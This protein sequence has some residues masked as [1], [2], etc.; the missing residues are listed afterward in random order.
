MAAWQHTKADNYITVDRFDNTIN[1]VNRFIT[2]SVSDR[3]P[4][5]TPE[6]Y[7][8]YDNLSTNSR[9]TPATTLLR[10]DNLQRL[11]LHTKGVGCSYD[12][13]RYCD[14]PTYSNPTATSQ[15]IELPSIETSK[16]MAV[17]TALFPLPYLQMLP[18]P[19][20]GHKNL[21]SHHRLVLPSVQ[22]RSRGS[23]IL[24]G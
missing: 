13:V 16:G 18:T 15:G 22:T 11:R 23:S 19:S 7:I 5:S 6:R 4:E 3:G 9:R 10:K 1:H 24:L 2:G 20:S 8:G 14:T 17:Q 21:V 12:E